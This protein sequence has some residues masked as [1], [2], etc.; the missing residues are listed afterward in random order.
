MCRSQVCISQVALN[1][2]GGNLHGGN[3]HR[4]SLH[5]EISRV[6]FAAS[7]DLSLD[8]RRCPAAVVEMPPVP[9]NELAG[10]DVEQ[11]VFCE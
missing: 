4:L 5:G 8:G 1:L 3:L 11:G 2:H 9:L 7:P 6:V 10:S